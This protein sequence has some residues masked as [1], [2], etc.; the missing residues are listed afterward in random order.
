MTWRKCLKML[1]MK[2]IMSLTESFILFWQQELHVVCSTT[3]KSLTGLESKIH[4]KHL[5]RWLRMRNWSPLSWLAKESMDLQRTWRVQAQV[6]IVLW[7]LDFRVKLEHQWVMILKRASMILP[8]GQM[9]LSFGQ[10]FYQ[11]NVHSQDAN[12]LILIRFVLSLQQE[13]L[14]CICL[15][16]M[17]SQVFTQISSRW[18]QTNGIVHLFQQLAERNWESSISAEPAAIY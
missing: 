3:K 16:A 1:S 7:S 6:L 14:V 5:R 9:S 17:L 12:L 4:R 15:I 8:H 10:S 11:M 18:I 2:D 13:R